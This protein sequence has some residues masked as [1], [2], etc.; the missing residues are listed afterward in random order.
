MY[1][2]G[3]LVH[4][5]LHVHVWCPSVEW[6]FEFTVFWLEVFTSHS[7]GVTTPLVLFSFCSNSLWGM[8]SVSRLPLEKRMAFPSPHYQHVP[9]EN[10]RVAHDHGLCYGIR[11]TSAYLPSGLV[12]ASSESVLSSLAPPPLL[13]QHSHSSRGGSS[14]CSLSNSTGGL[15]RRPS[16]TGM[17]RPVNLDFRRKAEKRASID[18]NAYITLETGRYFVHGIIAVVVY[19]VAIWYINPFTPYFILLTFVQQTRSLTTWSTR[20]ASHGRTHTKLSLTTVSQWQTRLVHFDV[21]L[22]TNVKYSL[23]WLPF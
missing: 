11:Y 7:T 4:P 17:S 1:R 19:S 13:A 15:V 6:F 20:T 22:A 3:L 18:S 21:N 5:Y 16:L 9:A 23:C 10:V 2:L 12:S 14:S 8:S